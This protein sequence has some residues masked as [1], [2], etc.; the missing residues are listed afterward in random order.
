MTAARMRAIRDLTNMNPPTFGHMVGLDAST[1][2]LLENRSKVPTEDELR[3]YAMTENV[4]RYKGITTEKIN[5]RED[6]Y[7]TKG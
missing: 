5:E 2:C 3:S 6:Y 4:L 1:I 7:A